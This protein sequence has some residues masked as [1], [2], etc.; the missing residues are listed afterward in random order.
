MTFAVILILILQGYEYGRSGNPTRCVLEEC[1]ASLDNGKHGM[2]FASG[3]GAT[4]CIFAMLSH[5][6]HIVCGDDMYG[7]TNRLFRY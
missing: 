1:I 4:T 3:L 5:G 6:D 7:G 2:C